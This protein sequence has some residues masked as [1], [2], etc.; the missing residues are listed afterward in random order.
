MASTT[1]IIDTSTTTST[2]ITTNTTTFA[3]PSA[4]ASISTDC[5]NLSG[6]NWNVCGNDRIYYGIGAGILLLLILIFIIILIRSCCCGRSSDLNTSRELLYPNSIDPSYTASSR[7]SAEQSL[8]SPEPVPF[9]LF[10]NP[11]S[12]TA[13]KQMASNPNAT[14]VEFLDIPQFRED[15]GTLPI[16]A[17]SKNRY[18]DII[19]NQRSIVSLSR[20]G[21]ELSTY[22]NANYVRGWGPQMYIATQAP[23]IHTVEVRKFL[24]L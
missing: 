16:G 15:P 24:L 17:A 14:A 11:L 8:I 3:S 20:Q 13:L 4:A 18:N 1:K 19:P 22:I 23:M 21:S 7:S 12:I 2:P 9:K 5:V 6:L 10:S